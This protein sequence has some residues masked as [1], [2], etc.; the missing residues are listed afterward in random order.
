V[1]QAVR[2]EHVLPA[3]RALVVHEL[4]K[5]LG[6]NQ[7]EAARMLGITP[8]AVSQYLEGKRGGK[9]VDRVKRSRQLMLTIS[10]LAET[11]SDR[12]RKGLEMDFTALLDSSYRVMS[13]LAGEK[14]SAP[15][16]TERGVDEGEGKE[17]RTRWIGILKRRLA[18]EQQAAQRSMGLALWTDNDLVKGL[19]RQ[20][21]SDSLRHAEI[22]ASLITYLEVGGK[23]S[24]LGTPNVKELEQILRDEEEADDPSINELKAIRDPAVQLLLDSIEADEKKHVVL[25]R[26]LLKSRKPSGA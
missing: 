23:P 7:S 6:H 16:A 3:V 10:N 8:A 26:G 21:A 25:L 18:S 24:G 19:F 12:S 11:A 1:K 9:L 17:Q 15:G 14:L 13:I 22:V 5:R 20:I 4:V 2:L